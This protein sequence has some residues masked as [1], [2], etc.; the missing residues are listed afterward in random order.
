MNNNQNGLKIKPDYDRVKRLVDE[1]LLNFGVEQAPIPLIQICQGYN[2]EIFSMDFNQLKQP[3]GYYD[4]NLQAN[5]LAG[6]LNYN[7]ELDRGDVYINSNE[8]KNRQKFTLA[9]ELGHFLLH[10]EQIRQNPDK[11]AIVPSIP[12]S[13]QTDAIEKEA[14]FFAAS[15]LVPDFLLSYYTSIY[16]RDIDFLARSIFHVSPTVVSYRYSNA[17]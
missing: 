2:L 12:G 14:N 5:K 6:F 10:K 17:Y 3:E 13:I 16:G 11:Y 7:P 9:H 1:I 15:L 8:S 4:Y